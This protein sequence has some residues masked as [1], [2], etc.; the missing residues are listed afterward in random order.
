MDTRLKYQDTIK[1]IL[2]K[3]AE[4]R[5]ALPDAYD[6]QVLFDDERGHYLVLEVFPKKI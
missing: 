4:Y 2:Q 1:S 5:A 6:S 3:H